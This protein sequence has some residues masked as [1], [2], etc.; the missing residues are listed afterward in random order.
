MKI[1]HI[2]R[3]KDDAY[4]WEIA[5]TQSRDL[6]AE[7]IVLLL[8]DAVFSPPQAGLKVFTCKDDLLARGLEKLFP[9]L[10]YTEI[11]QLVFECDTVHTW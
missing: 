8:H 4:P 10:D 11:V 6:N 9:S 3:C 2:L 7:V 5:E 1:L